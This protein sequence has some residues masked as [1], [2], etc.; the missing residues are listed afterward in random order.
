MSKKGK[1]KKIMLITFGVILLSLG[2]IL[3][4]AL[5]YGKD[6][7][8]NVNKTLEGVDSEVSEILYLSSISANSH[9]SQCWKTE[10]NPVKQEITISVDET[11]VLNVVDPLKRE[12]YISIG[13]YLETM[14][15]A[16]NA[17]GY[18]T[19]IAYGDST[20]ESI[21]SLSYSFNE[22]NPKTIDIVTE[23]I[24]TRHTNK[25]KYKDDSI[26]SS[27]ISFLIEKYSDLVYY[28]KETDN[29]AYLKQG[30]IAASTVQSE[31]EEYREELGN[32]LRLSN[33]EVID[34]QDGISAEMIGLKGI[35]KAFYY[36]TASHSSA[37]SDSFASQGSSTLNNQVNNM[38]GFFVL[39]SNSDKN[40]LID[41]GRKLQSF[42]YDSTSKEIAI[43]PLSAM[44]EVEEFSSC[45]KDDLGVD[46]TPQMILRAGYVSNYGKNQGIRRDLSEYVTVIND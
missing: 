30:T 9:N 29:F 45:V 41:C 12:A 36:W 38:A 15:M 5:I 19:S 6:T 7:K 39:G 23:L 18:S 35:V 27:D 16:F 22:N 13:C 24:N 34:K 14:N 3:I 33:D 28:D 26:N 10:I 42:W 2:A 21:A 37:L 25:E 17:Y 40:S 31:S 46:F 1:I 4:T 8:I 11:R 43:Q 32:W 44:L 20:L